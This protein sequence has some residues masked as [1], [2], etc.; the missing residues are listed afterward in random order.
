LFETSKVDFTTGE[1]VPRKGQVV[2]VAE[3]FHFESVHNKIV[4]VVYFIN[5]DMVYWLIIKINSSN[6]SETLEYIKE[7]WDDLN[8]EINYAPAL[9]NDELDKLY[10]SE[11][12]F[13]QLFVIFSGLAI[14]IACL[15]IFGLASYTAEQRTKEIGIRKVMGASIITI[16]KLINREFLML[17]LIS[18]IIA[19]P[20]A[21]YFMKNWLDNFTY[22]IDLSVWPF[23]FSGLIAIIIALISVSYQ[24]LKASSTNPIDA[25]R[26]E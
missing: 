25:L 4:P 26:Y 19:W 1:W 15:G 12:R 14:V 24:A 18:N 2:G 13:F 6:T 7:K 5:H 8:V 10:R 3:D 11:Q 22:R 16:I 9:Y 20:V 17:V 23:I 21:W